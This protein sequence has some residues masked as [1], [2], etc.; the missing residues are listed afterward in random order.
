[1]QQ[2]KFHNLHIIM[3][4][5]QSSNRSPSQAASVRR[6]DRRRIIQIY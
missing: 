6:N 3:T 2:E 5:I 1:M 4:I